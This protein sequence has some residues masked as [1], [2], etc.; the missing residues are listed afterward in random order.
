MC[1]CVCV[2]VCQL[3]LPEDQLELLYQWVLLSL[4]LIHH[5]PQHQ[6]GR[7]AVGQQAVQRRGQE[8][9]QP[10]AQMMPPAAIVCSSSS[11]SNSRMG[12]CQRGAWVGIC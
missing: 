11:S 9:L 7:P 8:Q 5:P 12:R 3:A 1:V 4:G 10:E 6:P 2:S